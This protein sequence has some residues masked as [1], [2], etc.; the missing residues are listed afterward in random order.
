MCRIPRWY[1]FIKTCLLHKD[2]HS[3]HSQP[4]YTNGVT[5]AIYNPVLEIQVL[6][7]RIIKE[8][9]KSEGRQTRGI[10]SESASKPASKQTRKQHYR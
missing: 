1:R 6:I 10:E 3:C 4:D 8:P 2:S 9:R 5:G 7:R